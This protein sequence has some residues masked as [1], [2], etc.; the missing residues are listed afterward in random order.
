[1][2]NLE[3]QK[4]KL[5]PAPK[6]KPKMS[7]ATAADLKDFWR[8]LEAIIAH[9]NLTAIITEDVSP[10]C[11]EMG[12]FLHNRLD[13][14]PQVKADATD[15]AN[16]LVLLNQALL[17]RNPKWDVASTLS[18]Q[19]VLRGEPIRLDECRTAAERAAW[20]RGYKAACAQ[21]ILVGSPD[22]ND[23]EQVAADTRMKELLNQTP[24]HLHEVAVN[25]GRW[26]GERMHG[27]PRTRSFMTPEQIAHWVA[28]RKKAGRVIDIETCELGGWYAYDCDPYGVRVDLPEEMQQVGTNRYVR[29][30]DSSGWIHEG[31]LPIEKFRAMYDR[32]DREFEE[33]AQA[34]PDHPRAQAHAARRR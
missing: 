15:I 9:A 14:W 23:A 8:E 33:W 11:I 18:G 25:G 1:L 20:R 17:I 26:S 29:S 5:T 32:I 28:S 7:Q 13:L 27:M 4:A 10:D 6:G 16:H 3:I 34:N 21:K 24:E 31:D 2:V 22:E 12:D 19:N 30:P